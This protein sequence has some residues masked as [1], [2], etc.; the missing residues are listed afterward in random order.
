MSSIFEL[1]SFARISECIKHLKLKPKEDGWRTAAQVYLRT[2]HTKFILAAFRLDLWSDFPAKENVSVGIAKKHLIKRLALFLLDYPIT[3]RQ[4]SWGKFSTKHEKK[5][6]IDIVCA[7]FK[8]DGTLDSIEPYLDQSHGSFRSI[9]E[10]YMNLLD[11]TMVNKYNELNNFKDEYRPR[12]LKKDLL[13][14][15][16]SHPPVP[17]NRSKDASRYLKRILNSTFIHFEILTAN[18][19]H[20][21]VSRFKYP[22]FIKRKHPGFGIL[23]ICCRLTGDLKEADLWF[24][25]AH[26]SIDGVPM[27][28]I[29]NSLKARWKTCGELILPSMSYKKNPIIPELCST[30]SGPSGKYHAEKLV[31][32]RPLLKIREELNQKYADKLSSPITVISMLGWGLG[33]HY[34][35]SKRRFLFPVD[36]AKS[37]NRERTLGFVSIRP[38]KYIDNPGLVDSFLEYQLAFNRKLSRA[39]ARINGIYKLF[40]IFALLP[41][42]VYWFMQRF[43][44]KLFSNVLGSIVI[45]TIKDADFFVAPSS[46]VILEGFIAFGNFSIPTKDGKI[47][48][49]VSVKTTKDNVGLYLNAIEEIAGD[50]GKYL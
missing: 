30:T 41:A 23:N 27:Q 34:I 7:V 11:R 46:D 24:Q 16:K 12:G 20:N 1:C 9:S 43:M 6:P 25:I 49:I 13:K 47:A 48:G 33:Q 32:F 50:F 21:D 3:H 35:F 18:D 5:D 4:L 31:D 40:E 8:A 42:P 14:W 22:D 26:V 38:S 44:I 39:H 17:K 28:E 29:L 19:T 37:D 45:T 2:E 10:D 15:L 36:L